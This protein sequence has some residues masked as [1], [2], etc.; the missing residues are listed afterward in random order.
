MKLYIKLSRK[1][2]H[3]T[4]IFLDTKFFF[5]EITNGSSK[6]RLYRWWKIV[7]SMCREF[8]PF[9]NGTNFW[10]TLITVLLLFYH[11][12]GSQ[13]GIYSLVGYTAVFSLLLGYESK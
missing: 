10:L 2:V 5:S 6:T 13:L 11:K 12:S 1:V 4:I 7:D 3:L 8:I 9:Q